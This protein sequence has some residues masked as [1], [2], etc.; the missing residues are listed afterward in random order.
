M[1]PRSILFA[2][3]RNAARSLIAESCFNAADVA[4]WRAFSAGWS[5]GEAADREA[6]SVL[7]NNGLPS[8]GLQPKAIE[9]FF[10]EGAPRIDLCIFMDENSLGIALPDHG[11]AI[12]WRVPD[13][14]LDPS[15]AAYL[16]VLDLV[17]H[18]IAGLIVSGSIEPRFPVAAVTPACNSHAA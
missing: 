2:G 14:S 13:P 11:N 6:L 5:P 3:R 15:P 4:E 8:E 9:L 10:L 16:R 12:C 1:Q 7:K 18:A 17:G